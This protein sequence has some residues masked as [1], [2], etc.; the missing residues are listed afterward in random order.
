MTSYFQDAQADIHLGDSLAVMAE[1]P[2]RSVN[3]IV[4]S[5]PFWGLRVYKGN[6]GRVWEDGWRGSF[7]LEPSP[8][9]YISHLMEFMAGMWRVLRD[10]GTCYVEL[11]DTAAGSGGNNTNVPI[12][13]GPGPVPKAEGLKPLSLIPFRFALACQEAGWIVRSVNIWDKRACMPESVN[14]WRW[15]KHKVKIKAQSQG[16]RPQ[17]LG[18]VEGTKAKPQ[19]NSSGGEWEGNAEW[20][21]CPGCPVCEPNDGLV[22]WRGAWRP[23]KAHSYIFQLTKTGRYWG[24]RE[25]VREIGA[26]PE[27]TLAA[28]GSQ[29]RYE[30]HKVNA[31]PAEYALYSGTRNMRSVWHITPEGLGSFRVDGETISH[32]A[33]FPRSLPRKCILASCPPFV[34]PKC[35]EPWARVVENKASEFNIQVRDAK[36]GRG[37]AEEGYR[38]TEEEIECYPGNHPEGGDTRTLGHRATCKCPDVSQE[39]TE[40]GVV[41]DP[42]MG[43]GTTLLAAR[44]LG[45][46]AI[47]IDTSE[48]YCK[49]AAHRLQGQGMPMMQE[50][51]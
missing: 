31:R 17:R 50:T 30:E 42:F 19:R 1:M 22:L 39:Q 4:T 27:G 35:R 12:L 16:T 47:G 23:T 21:D 38:A 8:Q 37:T 13:E 11:G 7:G 49:L 28:K 36:T 46:R 20:A 2:E 40:P 14:A 32:C 34:C 41:L 18:A 33:A 9:L 15:E 3:A 10:D 48:S 25:A 44:E 43:S 45:R 24:D 26:I 51:E 5:P 6:T 29:S